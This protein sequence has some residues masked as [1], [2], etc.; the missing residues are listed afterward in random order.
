MQVNK[1][2]Q[3]WVRPGCKLLCLR[4]HSHQHQH[5]NEGEGGGCSVN[6]Y[7]LSGRRVP[8]SPDDLNNEDLVKSWQ[9]VS[10]FLKIYHKEGEME[11]DHGGCHIIGAVNKRPLPASSRPATQPH[12]SRCTVQQLGHCEHPHHYHYHHPCGCHWGPGGG[13]W[14]GSIHPAPNG[15]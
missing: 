11:G 7:R 13:R 4:P 3:M 8:N 10:H 15:D 1:T 2:E 14:T 9:A 5:H 12:A 6:C